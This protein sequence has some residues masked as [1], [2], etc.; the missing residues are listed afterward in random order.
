MIASKVQSRK[1]YNDRYVIALA[2]ITNTEIFPF[3]AVVVFNL[4]NHEVLF[5]NRKDSGNCK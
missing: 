3:K 1:L 5:T 2:Q 4:L